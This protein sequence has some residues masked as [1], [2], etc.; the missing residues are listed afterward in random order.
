MS[1]VCG[2]TVGPACP[3]IVLVVDVLAMPESIVM[4]LM[5]TLRS[6]RSSMQNALGDVVDVLMDGV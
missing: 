3:G 2:A 5:L 1:C 4:L 6:E